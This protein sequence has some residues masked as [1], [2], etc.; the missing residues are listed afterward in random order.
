MYAQTLEGD[1]D[2]LV[3]PDHMG[4]DILYSEDEVNQDDDHNEVY[5]RLYETKKKEYKDR[6]YAERAKA[7]LVEQARYFEMVREAKM[8]REAQ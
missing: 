8:Y 2:S 1:D 5:R 4:G 7:R 6:Y 3:L